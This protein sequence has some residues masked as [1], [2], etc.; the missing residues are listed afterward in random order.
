[1]ITKAELVAIDEA[2]ICWLASPDFEYYKILDHRYLIVIETDENE[3]GCHVADT[4]DEVKRHIIITQE[5]ADTGWSVAAV[6]D[7]VKHEEL[8]FTVK[9]TVTLEQS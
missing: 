5:E 3:F 4:L 8:T 9:M 2:F 1:M 7:L 6:Y